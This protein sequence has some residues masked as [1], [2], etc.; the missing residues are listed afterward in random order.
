LREEDDLRATRG[1]IRLASF[2][3][4]VAILPVFC[5]SS[6]EPKYPERQRHLRVPGDFPT[7]QAAIDGAQDGDT[8]L[9]SPGTYRDAGNVN[10]VVRDK[11]L[12]LIG[13]AGPE[14]TVI[15]CE[16]PEETQY[17][18]RFFGSSGTRATLKGM[19]ITGA[20]EESPGSAAVVFGNADILMENCSIVNTIGRALFL[21]EATGRVVDSDVANNTSQYSSSAL[22][23]WGGHLSFEGCTFRGNTAGDAVVRISDG[24]AHFGS[25]YF[26]GNVGGGVAAAG[27]IV[28]IY[29]SL[30]I[31]NVTTTWGGGVLAEEGSVLHVSSCTIAENAAAMEGGGIAA[32]SGCS[33]QLVQDIVWGNCSAGQ[34]RDILVMEGGAALVESCLFDST[35]SVFGNGARYVGCQVYE[36]PRFCDSV[37]CWSRFDGNYG[38]R[39]GSPALPDWNECHIFRGWGGGGWCDSS[40]AVVGQARE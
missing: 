10:L 13:I 21:V 3:I 15:D 33:L 32:R 20:I 19:T 24:I 40:N 30:L 35:T 27:S 39:L 9:I 8:V 34:A 38:L 4:L 29:D 28:W 18:V 17:G 7:I 23:M 22:A 36:D 16:G 5:T 2:W 31:H 1:R 37:G 11:G 6:T 12:A 14:S 26:E 25:C